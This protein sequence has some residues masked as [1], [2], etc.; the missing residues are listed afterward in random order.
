MRTYREPY[1]PPLFWHP[2]TQEIEVMA[3]ILRLLASLPSRRSRIDVA[4]MVVT[5]RRR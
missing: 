2:T 3:R 5:Y 1:R 4:A